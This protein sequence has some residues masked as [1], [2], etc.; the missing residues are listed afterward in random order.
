MLET[1]NFGLSKFTVGYDAGCASELTAV[2]STLDRTVYCGGYPTHLYSYFV[3]RE[4]F[5]L[6][7]YVKT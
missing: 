1:N 7:C 3:Q 5:R 4:H 6:L 2:T